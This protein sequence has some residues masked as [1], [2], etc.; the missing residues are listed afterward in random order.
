[1]GNYNHL[2]LSERQIL[3]TLLRQGTSINEIAIQL[4]RNRSSLYRELARNGNNE[5]YNPIAAEHQALT[6]RSQLRRCKIERHNTLRQYVMKR[7]KIG[8]SPEQIAGRLKRKKSKYVICHE[9]IYSFIYRQKNKKLYLL[10]AKKKPKRRRQYA[11]KHQSCRFGNRRIITE[12]PSY[13]DKRF[14]YGHWE[15]DRIEFIGERS[16]A[17]TTLVER[18][19]RVVLLIKNTNKTSHQ[20]MNS[21]AKKFGQ[22]S[23]RLCKTIT[24]DQGNEF[25]NFNVLERRLN[26]KIFYCHKHAP[27][28]KGTNENMNGRIRR[29]LP[30]GLKIDDISQESLDQLSNSLNNTPRKCLDYKT[31]KELFL[32][33]YKSDCRS[34]F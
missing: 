24:F 18:K 34:W 5:A 9:T 21:I 1:M 14:H 32:K 16:A 3:Y 33:H 11:R 8:W 26:C 20:V 23:N 28:E 30:F 29:Y 13:I 25:A 10:L 6:K 12:R 27:W 22:S 17:I 7:L 19:T 4:G 2:S 15:G 31:P